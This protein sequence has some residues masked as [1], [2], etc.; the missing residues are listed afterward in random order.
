MDGSEKY[1][2]HL[3][4]WLTLSFFKRVVNTVEFSSKNTATVNSY[5]ISNINAKKKQILVT[6]YVDTW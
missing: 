6:Y 2:F 1:L 4:L 5:T 3:T